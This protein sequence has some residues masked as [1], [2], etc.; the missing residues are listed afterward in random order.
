[1]NKKL[2]AV[3]VLLSAL[4]AFSM[5]HAFALNTK[6]VQGNQSD[7]VWT[8]VKVGQG[9]VTLVS[10]GHV[11]VVSASGLTSA[12][13]DGYLAEHA[14]ASADLRVI[15]VAQRA[16]ASGTSQLVLAKGR[17]TV[18]IGE[19]VTSQSNLAIT[20]GITLSSRAGVV[21][22]GV[23]ISSVDRVI[24]RPVATALEANTN[25]TTSGATSETDAYINCL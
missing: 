7:E 16:I 5:Q 11:L 1:M 23:N 17:G 14:R 20:E 18:R 24:G 3:F 21:V 22:P 19:P 4:F 8:E 12:D 9:Y 13:N 2:I 10:R 15:G 6:G 25:T